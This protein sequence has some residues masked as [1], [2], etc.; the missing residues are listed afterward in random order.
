M[1][2]IICSSAASWTVVCCAERSR[3]AASGKGVVECCCSGTLVSAID[4]C[5]KRDLDGLGEV[6]SY[7]GADWESLK[8]P[9]RARSCSI[10]IKSHAREQ[11]VHVHQWETLLTNHWYL[12]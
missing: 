8:M 11:S 3:V 12:R 2:L 9:L 5:V 4:V 1:V 7:G 6:E 10:M